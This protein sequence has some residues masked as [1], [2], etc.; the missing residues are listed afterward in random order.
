MEEAPADSVLPFREGH[1]H[2]HCAGSPGQH[3]NAFEQAERNTSVKYGGTGLGLAISSRLVQMMGGTLG[4]RSEPGKGS[5][6]FFTL[7]LPIGIKDVKA[8]RHREPEHHDFHGKRLLVVEDNQLNQEIAQSLLEMEGF[9]VETA[10]TGRLPWMRSRTMNR[11][12]TT[13]CSWIS[14]CL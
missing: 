1:R 8:P 13:R 11:N 4:V 5:E 6:F 14:V 9:L 7:C 12:I 3:F 10:E 2:R